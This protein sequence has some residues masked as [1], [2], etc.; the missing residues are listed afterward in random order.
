MANSVSS[1]AFGAPHISKV[2]KVALGILERNCDEHLAKKTLMVQGYLEI[3]QRYP[4]RDYHVS[5]NKALADLTAAI[6]LHLNTELN[7]VATISTR[8]GQA[9]QSQNGP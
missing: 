2:L 7:E 3:S 6:H 5:L 1:A 4:E 9:G 8:L